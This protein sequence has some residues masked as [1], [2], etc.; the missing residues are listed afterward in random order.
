MTARV[1]IVDADSKVRDGLDELLARGFFDTLLAG[2]RDDALRLAQRE[3]PDL[4]LLGS[5]GEDG[6]PFDLCR[7]I[8]AHP[9][10]AHLPVV[11]V[12]AAERPTERLRALSVGADDYLVRPIR[13]AELHARVRALARL[14]LTADEIRARG[15][16]GLLGPTSALDVMEGDEAAR[17]AVIDDGGDVAP[18]AIGSLRGFGVVVALPID[19][20]V[21][22]L[23]KMPC[24]LV[25]LGIEPGRVDGLRLASRLRSHRETRSLPLFAL[26]ACDDSV[27]LSKAFELGISDVACLPADPL[28]VSARA[29][30]LLR[31]KRLIDRLRENVMLSM[32]LAT[33]DAVTGVYNRHYL[34]HHLGGSVERAKAAGRPLTL[35]MLDL[36][37]FKRVNDTHGHSAGDRA[38]AS[39]AQRLAA[40]VRGIDLVARYGGEE[41]A[42]LMP[43]TDLA[44]AKVIAERIRMLVAE[45]PHDVGDTALR[46]TVSIGLATLRAE[47]ATSLLSRADAALYA[48]KAD[49]RN[50]VVT[51]SWHAAA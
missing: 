10:T 49:G 1:L 6:D 22:R 40:N 32:R 51:E 23:R 37:Y 20:A 44:A 19:S 46:L 31:R 36:D 30:T 21:D 14:K 41:F 17:I 39:V 47:D 7:A 11:L 26:M 38:L 3:A 8:K 42:V 34:Q 50:R 4:V 43:D 15:G 13:E 27:L 5:L 28:E 33:T 18:E 29:R 48:A 35:M 25:V 9:E 16:L 12:S 2:D 24:D 45:E